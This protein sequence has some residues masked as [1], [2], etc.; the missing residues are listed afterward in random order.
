MSAL[1]GVINTVTG[2]ASKLGGRTTLDDFLSEFSPAGGDL[3]KTPDPLATFDVTFKI[4]PCGGAGFAEKDTSYLSKVG[5]KLAVAA[6]NAINNATAGLL[7]SAMT[8]SLDQARQDHLGKSL[9]NSFLEYLADANLLTSGN[10]GGMTGPDS[11]LILDLTMFT[12]S[13]TIPR[14]EQMDTGSAN[15]TQFGRF[16]INGMCCAPDSNNLE[17]TMINTKVP[18]FERI[19]YP[20]LREVTLPYW[21]YNSQPYSTALITVDMTRHSD[22][23]YIF[24]GC[25]PLSIQ[26]QQPSQDAS[27]S[28]ITRNVTMTFDYMF[29]TSSMSIRQ[30]VVDKLIGGASTLVNSAAK[31]FNG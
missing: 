28:A 20:W 29:V 5:N 19:F 17:F 26:M 23:K 1:A 21:S 3:I 2:A 13:I 25:R 12:Q 14:I 30:S 6:K 9:D 8:K 24:T 15:V 27:G 18:I 11:P 31:L 7:A 10:Y 4:K 16:P 22:I